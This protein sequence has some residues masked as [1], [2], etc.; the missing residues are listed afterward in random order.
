MVTQKMLQKMHAGKQFVTSLDLV[1]CL[2]QIKEQR[3]LLTCTPISELP[4]NIS[5]II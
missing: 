3:L 1:N 2:K 5:T 4:S